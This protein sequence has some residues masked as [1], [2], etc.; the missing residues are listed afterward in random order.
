MH[1]GASFTGRTL[2]AKEPG[3]CSFPLSGLQ[4]AEGQLEGVA[5]DTE[6]IY[7]TCHRADDRRSGGEKMIKAQIQSPV[8][9]V[10]LM[11]L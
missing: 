11:W 4:A 6:L 9:L 7:N 3:K 8:P 1:L 5:M 10:G 2:P